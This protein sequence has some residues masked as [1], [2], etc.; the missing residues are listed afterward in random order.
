MS[1]WWNERIDLIGFKKKVL[2]KAFPVHHSFFLGEISLFCFL[3]LIITGIFLALNYE[4][5]GRTVTTGGQN[6]T[7]AYASVLY[8]DSLPFGR[9]I[10][11]AH[12]WSAHLFIAAALLHLLR[13]LLT[14]SYK[15]PREINWLLGL[16][17][18]GLAVMTAFTGYALP[19]DDFAVTATSIG[20]GMAS[21]IPWGGPWVADV[22]FGG[23]YPTVR[24]LPR[25]FAVHIF[26]LPLLLLALIAVHLMLVMKQL[27]TQ[28]A[29]AEKVSPGKMLGVPLVPSQAAMMMALFLI[30]LAVIFGLGGAFDV[31]PIKAFGPPTAS[32]PQVKPD[33]YFLWIYGILEIIPSSWQFSFLDGRF[34]P[35]FFGGI[36]IPSLLVLAAVLLPF[37]DRS[38]FELRYVEQPSWHPLRTSAAVGLLSFFIVATLAGYHGSLQISVA[39]LRFLLC[40]SPPLVAFV[41]YSLIVRVVPRKRA[42]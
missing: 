3:S 41:F 33:W 36:L 20:Y 24:S 13:H 28:P 40:L 16:L 7:I 5:S 2:R 39:L 6:V 4:A 38:R 19:D 30:T 35:E 22:L 37:L 15:K 14:G 25:L 27:H 42:S 34:G 8:I 26:M 12:H 29:Y 11:S 21:A 10:R 32:T 1:H 18:L 31:H 9:V 23:H 17:L